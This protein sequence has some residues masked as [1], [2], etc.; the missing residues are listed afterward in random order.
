VVVDGN[1]TTFVPFTVGGRTMVSVDFITAVF[2]VTVN[3][4]DAGLDI[5]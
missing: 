2:Q 4:L 3:V 5:F 1:I